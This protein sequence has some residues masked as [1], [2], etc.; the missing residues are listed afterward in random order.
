MGDER[1]SLEPGTLGGGLGFLIGG[2]KLGKHGASHKTLLSVL[3]LVLNFVH[4]DGDFVS[5]DVT[6]SAGGSSKD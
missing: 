1:G 3:D 6:V 5:G 4:G 2:L